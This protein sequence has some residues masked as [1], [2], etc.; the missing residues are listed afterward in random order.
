MAPLVLVV[1]DDLLLSDVLR[2]YLEN[3]G[4]RVVVAGNGLEG[5]TR[6]L[7]SSP[8]LVVLDVMLPRLNGWEVCRQIRA[9]SQVPV[10]L[11]TARGEETDKLKGFELGADD[12]LTKPFSMQEFLARVRAVLKR[13]M[14]PS[15]AAA[16]AAVQVEEP[17]GGDGVLSFPGLR[18]DRQ[19]HR[20]ERNGDQVALTPKE[21]D[22]L[23]YLASRGG[24]VIRRDELLQAV[25]GYGMGEDDRTI[26]THVNRL[27]A[28]LEGG[29]YRYIHTAWGVGYKFEA[30]EGQG[31]TGDGAP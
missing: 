17:A 15:L 6:A 24:I 8:A 21:F 10:I 22:L 11:L 28:K 25:W 1:E 26:H 9:V 19:R 16:A 14:A 31:G 20:V 27:R 4:Y 23:W 30:A 29:A 18:I 2:M 5:L 3:E 13:T 7:G 12:Y